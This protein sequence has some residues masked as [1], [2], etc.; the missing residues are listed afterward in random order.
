LLSGCRGV[1]SI[2]VVGEDG[3]VGRQEELA[4]LRRFLGAAV[5]GTGG[6]LLVAGEAGV[7]K[8]ALVDHALAD[9]PMAAL[10]GGGGEEATAP[11]G[12][13]VEALRAYLRRA[14]DG[15]S[16][17]GTLSAYLALLL[18]E[19]G[20]PP[21]E[22]DRATLFESIRWAFATIAADEPPVVV[23]DDLHWADETTL[24]LLP[25]L[26]A[27][28]EE[29]SLALVGI[30]RSDEVQRGHQLRR[31]RT[32]LR[33]GGRLRELDVEPL[34]EKATASLCERLLGGPIGAS[35]AR[36]IFD[37]TQ[38]VPF[39]IEEL[40]AALEAEGGLREGRSGIELG[41]DQ[42]IP[43]PDSVRDAV[44]VR[45]EGLDEVTRR[46]LEVAAAIG[47]RFSCELV[48]TLDP[49]AELDEAIAR[50]LVVELGPDEAAFRHALAREAV[51]GELPWSRRRGLHKAIAEYLEAR[52]APVARIAVHWLA[53]RE[54][55]R[56][57]P[58]LVTAANDY[59]AMHAYRD[60]FLA[61]RRALEIW[62]DAEH[63]AARLAMLERLGECAELSG[64]PSEAVKAWRE[65]ADTHRSA[66][67]KLALARIQR[68]LAGVFERECQWD[69]AL[70]A[71]EEAAG[72][73]AAAGEPGEA[74]A[75]RLAA[76]VHVQAAGRLAPALELIAEAREEAEQ[77]SRRDLE[78]RAL[79]LEGQV[80][81]RSGRLEEALE[82]ARSGLS[83]ALAEQQTASAAE[84]YD[85]VGMVLADAADY[86]GALD[87]FAEA[88]EFCAANGEVARRQGCL[89]CVAWLTLKSG[90]WERSIEVS[91]ELLA[92]ADAPRSAHLVARLQL[93]TIEVLRGDTKRGR[94]LLERALADAE[95][96]ATLEAVVETTTALAR[97]DED[98]G[99]RE[100]ALAGCRRVLE[101]SLGSG[102]RDQAPPSN[103]AP[104]VRWAT[105]LFAAAGE[106]EGAGA[107]AEFLAQAVGPS[108]HRDALAALS[109]ALGEL[110]LLD[111][112]P[113]G[114]AR[115]FTQALELLRELGLPFDRAETQLRAGAALAAAGE[116]ELAVER[117][118]DAYR[119][120][121]RLR[122][123]P[124]ARRAAE[125]L[126]AI[127]EPVEKRL[128]RRAAAL[129]ERGGLSRRELEVMRLVSVGRTNRE[130]AR[131]LFLSPRTVDMHVRNILMKLGCRSRTEAT[132][133]AA[134]LGLIELGQPAGG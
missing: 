20:S 117:L 63:G 133:R 51:Y 83:L 16:G 32:E 118:V 45:A 60:A 43:I 115:H 113:E 134:E 29:A 103:A 100:G 27:S 47:T 89:A 127:G 30:Y 31:A 1:D 52:D 12:P 34:D 19:L 121:R 67:D 65:I 8:T 112:D 7:G 82:A 99:M 129:V 94:R 85:R 44:L 128:G 37:R 49:T 23:L 71:R 69:A 92:D 9:R 77:A 59:C 38:G 42:E 87:A 131:E 54:L 21:G 132:R 53:A 11:Y 110:A 126:Q 58:A 48:A 98:D 73:F 78:A 76:A 72:A 17:S 81:A 93:G 56:A 61:G 95:R 90:E 5:S 25:T 28:V 3:L 41:K 119:T 74:A 116:R 14:P 57:R 40:V 4:Q 97:A 102:D 106:R 88:T 101:L 130:I 33:R 50:G 35:L 39:F 107:C 13:V 91:R 114:A 22:A 75:E 62:P 24:A 66:G 80:L 109:H 46:G 18:P 2:A 120:A 84:C 68:R 10:R 124:L 123:R 104:S 111:G 105:S 26:A 64:D 125:E 15:L 70:A 36:V 108:S 122:A 96:T 79:G 55:E 6:L 86:A